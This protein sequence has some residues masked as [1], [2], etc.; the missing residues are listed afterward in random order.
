VRDKYTVEQ[1]ANAV[2]TAFC[3]SDVCRKL[4]VTVCT[5]NFK[6]IDQLLSVNGIS[7]N[8]FN[9]KK[10]FRR[11]KPTWTIDDV[12]CVNSLVHRSQLRKH[13][14]RAGLYDGKC[15]ECGVGEVWRGKPLT[16]ELDH[17]NGINDDNRIENL[18]WLCPNCH[19]QTPTHKNSSNRRQP[20]TV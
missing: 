2:A 18:R 10:T 12:F 17:V 4:N 14:K 20:L 9:V 3:M 11:N 16:I 6:R 1:L 13:A 8:H 5:F 15:S 7:K 19:S